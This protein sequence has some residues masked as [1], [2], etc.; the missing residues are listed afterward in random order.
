MV[1]FGQKWMAKFESSPCRS[2]KSINVVKHEAE[3]EGEVDWFFSAFDETR[4]R[5][6]P[7][8]SHPP[9]THML[10]QGGEPVG[11]FYCALKLCSLCFI[12]RKFE[13]LRVLAPVSPYG[14]P[15]WSQR[16]SHSPRAATCGTGDTDRPTQICRCV[17]S[18]TPS[19]SCV[20]TTP[21][22]KLH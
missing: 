19:H 11:N 14:S 10:G 8:S 9:F 3:S 22:N 17:C 7:L 18:P 13:L 20:P 16:E 15:H 2:S 4:R 1:I 5:A 21:R 6:I 12:A